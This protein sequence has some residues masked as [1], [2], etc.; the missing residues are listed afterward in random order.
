MFHP[1]HAKNS[2]TDEQ[3]IKKLNE[4]IKKNCNW[5]VEGIYPYL[6]PISKQDEENFRTGKNKKS[7]YT[8][9]EIRKTEET[10]DLYVNYRG[11]D[12]NQKT[13]ALKDLYSDLDSSHVGTDAAS[14][15]REKEL[16]AFLENRLKELSALE[17]EEHKKINHPNFSKIYN[18]V[19]IALS[20]LVVG[21]VAAIPFLGPAV[22]ITSSAV[23]IGAAVKMGVLGAIM[24][25]YLSLGLLSLKDGIYKKLCGI[26]GEDVKF[27]EKLV[28]GLSESLGLH[29][30]ADV[31]NALGSEHEPRPAMNLSN[32]SIAPS[33]EPQPV[34]PSVVLTDK[35]KAENLVKQG[36]S[37]DI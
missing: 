11:S 6:F 33:D 35:Q 4:L 13:C 26:K 22:A 36:N 24:G 7:C 3:R 12:G 29:A 27:R 31:S 23:F 17:L 8:S 10:L 16:K 5:R 19:V 9:I 15:E 25:G 2:P 28:D 32:G 30:D 18:G 1:I 34:E 14:A 37:Y 20:L 21:I